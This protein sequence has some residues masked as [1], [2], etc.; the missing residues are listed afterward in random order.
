MLDWTTA[1]Q[2][3]QSP[4]SGTVARV[5]PPT[6][7]EAFSA[8]KE[9]NDRL[10]TASSAFQNQNDYARQ[11]FDAFTAK[12]GVELPKLQFTDTADQGA[13]DYD[14]AYRTWLTASRA[15]MQQEATARNDPSLAP[16][17]DED[18]ARGGV[19]MARAALQRQ[20][21]LQRAPGSLSM[22]LG[23]TAA[24]AYGSVTDPYNLISLTALSL[25]PE[26]AP[27]LASVLTNA[28]AMAGQQAISDAARYAYRQQVDPSYGVGDVAKDVG[29]A[30]V[31]G[32]LFGAGHTLGGE[33]M[34]ATLGSAAGGGVGG[35]LL[36]GMSGGLSGAVEGALGGAALP[37][38]GAGFGLGAKTLGM[39]WRGLKARRPDLADGM[40]L[41]ARD[42]GEVAEKAGDLQAQ[43]PF[44]GPAGD[45]A[46]AEAID[47]AEKALVAGQPLDLPASTQAEAAARRGQVFYPGG[48]I[49]ARY[50]VAEHRDLVTSHDV[51]FRVRPDYPA[52][53][54]PRDRSGAPAQDQ[55]NSI[56]ADLQPDR[57]GPSPEANS[58]AP[59]V[60]PDGVVESGNG[61]VLAIGRAYELGRGEAYRAWLERQGFDTTG[62]D[63]PV[64]V[65]M[66]ETPMD[67]GQRA[68]FAH[69]ANGSAALRMSAT[70]Q[71]LSDARHIDGSTLDLAKGPDLA[72]AANR[73]FA[74]AVVAKLPPGERGELLTRDGSLSAGG[75]QRVR[76]AMT[77]RA[78]GDVSVLQRA[79]DHPDPNIKAIAGAMSDAAGPWARMRDAATRGDI[80]GGHDIT[81]DVLQAVK[82]IMRARDE[83]RPPW[84]VLNQGDIFQS[85]TTQLASRMFFRDEEMRQPAGRARVADALTAYAEEAAKNTLHGRLFADD[86]APLDVLRRTAEQAVEKIGA[87]F[88]TASQDVLAMVRAY[89]GTPHDFDRFDL[90]K[91]GTGEGNQFEGHGLYFAGSKAG[92]DEARRLI[93]GQMHGVEG[94]TYAVNLDTNRNRLL[95][96]HKDFADQSAVV[97][98]ALRKLGLAQEM[99]EADLAERGITREEYGADLDSMIG[100]SI[101]GRGL[102][103]Y[104]AAKEKYGSAQAASKALNDAGI[105]GIEYQGREKNY[106][107]FDDGKIE[108]THKNGEPVTPAEKADVLASMRR[109]ATGETDAERIARVSSHWLEEA[110]N[111]P[112]QAAKRYLDFARGVGVPKEK[113]AGV[114]A[115]LEELATS[116]REDISPA[117]RADRARA[118]GFD[119]SQRWYH[120]TTGDFDAFDL[121]RGGETTGAGNGRRAVFLAKDADL[122]NEYARIAPSRDLL[123]L[124]R[125][126]R[127]AEAAGD[128]ARVD[129]IDEQIEE[130]NRDGRAN[131]GGANIMPLHVRGDFDT[132]DFGGRAYADG[133]V[134]GAMDRAA[135][136]GKDGVRFVNMRDNPAAA[137]ASDVLAVF[138]PKNIRSVHA[139]FSKEATESSSLLARTQPASLRSAM[140]RAETDQALSLRNPR[141]GESVQ[142]QSAASLKDMLARFS[143][144][145]DVT[146]DPLARASSLAIGSR[147]GKLVGDTPVFVV[148]PAEMRTLAEGRM[149]IQPG[150]EPAG[151]FDPRAGH[152]VML[153][154]ALRNPAEASAL[155]LHEGAHAFTMR[156]I[157][158]SEA[159]RALV[160]TIRQAAI[161]AHTAAGGDIAEHYGL[162]NAHEFVSE[163]FSAPEFQRFLASVPASDAMVKAFGL[164]GPAHSLWDIL[165][166]AVR[167]ILGM[168]PDEHSLL[169]ATMRLGKILEDERAKLDQAGEG[170]D[171]KPMMRF[172]DPEQREDAAKVAAERARAFADAKSAIAYREGLDRVEQHPDGPLAGFLGIL[173]RDIR[174]RG[175]NGDVGKNVES[176]GQYYQDKIGAT[177]GKL[178]EAYG[179]KMAGLKQDVAGMHDVI[180]EMFGVDT[181]N[182]TAKAVADGM[183]AADTYATTEAKRLGKVFTAAEDWRMP[184]FWETSRALKFGKAAL[185]ADMDEHITTGGLRVFDPDTHEEANPL[186]LR[187]IV[188]GAADRIATDASR[189]T[190][191]GA[192]VFS[193]EMRV[194]RFADGAAGRDAYRALQDKYG[195]GRGGYLSVLQAHYN[196]IGRELGFLRVLGPNWQEVGEKLLSDTQLANRKIIANTPPRDAMQRVRDLPTDMGK[197]ATS[198]LES[199]AK[200]SSVWEHMSGQASG[201]G[202]ELVASIM[203][204]TRAYETSTKMGSA[205]VTAVPAD[206]VNFAMAAK[207][208][209]MDMGRLVQKTYEAFLADSPHLREEAERL[210]IAAHS[211]IDAAIG[212]KRFE[213][214]ILGEKLM[215]R[216]SDFVIRAQGLHVWDAAIRRV[217]LQEF[218]GTIGQRA[219]MAFEELDAPFARFLDQYG[220][221]A[222]AWAEMSNP[223]HMLPVGEAKYLHLDNLPEPLRVRLASAAYDQR[224]FAYLA[225]GTERVRAMSAGA[226][227][228]TLTGEVMRSVFLFKNFSMTMLATWG[229]RAAREAGAGRYGTLATLAVGMTMAGALATQ[230]RSVLQGKDPR[231]MKNPWFWAESALQGG[232]LG[233]W[234]DFLKD[235]F[236]RSDTSLTESLLGPLGTIPASIQGLTSGAR[237]A[238]EDGERVNFGAKLAK[239]IGDAPPGG[240]LWY[241]RLLTKR[242][243]T[244]NIQRMI[245]PEWQRSFARQQQRSMKTNQQSFYWAPG[246]NAPSRGPDLGA[247]WH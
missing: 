147:L 158:E 113:Q 189:G 245:D 9:A 190:A 12:T 187:A 172:A 75:V 30:A 188:D 230:A 224:Q 51:D 112:V 133:D 240:N 206:T 205:I 181:K 43:N 220:F 166:A 106:V 65:G 161:E 236:S 239:I 29:G 94:N 92:G 100:T 39:A 59:I 137:K 19:G 136:A 87:L 203:S 176:L 232:A 122:S 10:D 157:N 229:M 169:D 183:K 47:A 32:A 170:N 226:K 99:T 64:L 121:A 4:Y 63:K 103:I 11:R 17:N 60:G 101:A 228:G 24:G 83:G 61:R 109:S 139:A 50:D 213:D 215:K 76:A 49:D 235:A 110:D 80:A 171:L 167:K 208:L 66:R 72:T 200:A 159:A 123:D 22:L 52:D 225:G 78:F 184:Q 221:K 162:T 153:D 28:G 38:A 146:A 194:F 93:A 74:R 186:R 98:K 58:G 234:G 163:G 18:I 40:P 57:L 173:T 177:V 69:A 198:W 118:L 56:A 77:A 126:S 82:A 111:D 27:L 150:Y 36:G 152:I 241:S 201:V 135:A 71:A 20:A 227:A 105:H 48:S 119:P 55:V 247:M 222:D 197:L 164:E 53:L 95:I 25:A 97:K 117:D 151:F 223:E 120:G 37:L 7:T 124:E 6:L 185:V 134:S 193:N 178:T 26:G 115:R 31:G 195:A 141:T 84:E 13:A 211:G 116:T 73:D 89:H 108:I 125:Q 204:G 44:R 202:S 175:P 196:K 67:R 140:A 5:A 145:K 96:R 233:Y 107:I 218:F 128:G 238:A 156:T 62:I 131:G 192:S 214:Q 144:A 54:Q 33:G 148:G 45:A 14:S 231:D 35:A 155:T 85:D 8:T 191:N 243:I 68:D 104:N 2:D 86:V 34:R 41:V 160:D 21:G 143:V 91:V 79:L 210:G 46:H 217:F 242:L 154:D 3:Q 138:D 102:D 199:P 127:E 180:S 16:P 149:K 132:V 209:G 88:E 207:Y 23:S 1:Q 114:L 174:E 42:A 244:D 142:A 129:A 168:A 246:Q 219:G 81:G 90:S 179:S 70:E 237:R 212:T 130:M 182:E 165:V 15:R 216:M